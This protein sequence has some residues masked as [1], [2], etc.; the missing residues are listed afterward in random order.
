MRN[1]IGA[2]DKKLKREDTTNKGTLMKRIAKNKTIAYESRVYKIGIENYRKNMNQLMKK[3]KKRDIPVFISEVC[4]NVKDLEP[5][6]SV[7]TYSYPSASEVYASAIKSESEGDYIRAC[8]LYYQAKDLD[9]IRFR[10]SEDINEII[11]KLTM[12]YNAHLVPMKTKYFEKASPNGLIGNDLITEHVHPNIRGYFLMA[13]AFFTELTTSGILGDLN[14][15]YYKNSLYYQRNWGYSELD[16]LVGVHI[17]AILLSNWPYQSLEASSDKYRETYKPVSLVDSLAF[18]VVTSPSLRIDEAHR[19]LGD[20]Y[21]K[22]GDYFKAYKEYYS[23]VKY[24]PFQLRDYYLA[25]HCLTLTNDF[26]MALKLIDQSLA[27]KETFYANYIKGEILF[28]KG[29]YTGSLKA[30]NR[31]SAFNNS[32][33]T[34][35]R[36]LIGM[37]KVLYYS[38]DQLKANEILNEL[39]KID[40]GYQPVFPSEKKK[41]IYYLPLQVEILVN[42]AFELYKS[43]NYNEALD[44]FLK[45]LDIRETSLANRCIGDIMFMKNDSSSLVYYQ[46]A[47]PDYKD[48]IDFLFNMGILYL[49]YKQISK[50]K[51]IIE[52]MKHLDPGFDKISLLEKEIN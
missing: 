29:D 49:R 40:P 19:I 18:T 50:A 47:Y 6:C 10:A 31:A 7:V 9:C 52:E 36:I 22:N 46:K 37:Y 45:S 25:I 11:H 44:I 51:K 2:L 43:G 35:M 16:S 14:P 30:F 34:K 23:N 41:Y 28:L 33:D 39:Q 24:D 8:E 21:M 17:V 4:S 1:N 27:L 5:F 26:P 13:D 48:N 42:K 3:A 32:M 15:V 12:K 38:G 20:F